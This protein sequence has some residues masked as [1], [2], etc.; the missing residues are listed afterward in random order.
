MKTTMCIACGQDFASRNKLFKHLNDSGHGVASRNDKGGDINK[1]GDDDADDGSDTNRPQL[2]KGNDAYYEYY[3]RQKICENEQAWKEA[4]HELR[5]P[6]PVAYRIHESSSISEFSAQLLALIEKREL[7]GV[8]DE[9]KLISPETMPVAENQKIFQQW[10]FNMENKDSVPKLRMTITPHFHHRSKSSRNNK[11]GQD[12]QSD[13]YS[14]ILHALQELGAIHRQELVSAIPPLVLWAACS[15]EETGI[16]DGLIVADLCAAPG[17][18]SLQML[19]MLYTSTENNVPS[20]LLVVN[21][22]D[23]NRIVTLCQRSRHVPRAPMLAINMDA[24]YF[25]G[26]RRRVN[27]SGSKTGEGDGV[28]NVREKSGYKQKYDKVLCDV[29]CTG[30]G[31]TRKNK[32]IWNAWS[33]AHSMSLHRLQRKILRRAMELLRPGGM[34]VYSTCSLNPLEDEAVVASV[35]G[36]VG[37]VNAMEIVPLPDWLVRKCR[38]LNGLNGSWHVPNP[39]FGKKGMNDMYQRFQDVPIEHQGGVKDK[40]KKGGQINPSMFPPEK[41]SELLKQLTNCGRFVPQPSIG[42]DSGGFFVACIRRLHVGELGPKGK[43]SQSTS[44]ESDMALAEEPMQEITTKNNEDSPNEAGDHGPSADGRCLREGDWICVSCNEINF[45]KRGGSKCFGCKARKPHSLQKDK[46][47]KIQEPLLVKP[48]KSELEPFFE[49]FGIHTGLRSSF[50]LNNVRLIRRAK[51]HA[52]VV[53]SEALSK[54]SI[55]K[56]WS[57]VRELGITLAAFPN[58]EAHEHIAQGREFRLFDESLSILARYATRRHLKLHPVPFQNALAQSVRLL[59]ESSSPAEVERVK[60]TLDRSVPAVSSLCQRD[61]WYDS[62]PDSMASPGYFIVS[63]ECEIPNTRGGMG[64]FSLCG[65]IDAQGTVDL[66]TSL[67]VAAAMLVLLHKYSEVCSSDP[68]MNKRR[69][70]AV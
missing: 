3:L 35:I 69:R 8:K 36:D 31:T 62:L 18:K 10:S 57:P 14:P 22:S 7:G 32:Q 2:S 42:F 23:R 12:D 15:K 11:S 13:M 51:E 37:G 50:P 44:G 26:M 16:N 28:A 24:R 55:S 60:A 63:C 65:Y 20:G 5:R 64:R 46:G 61:M 4:Y 59:L 1:E 25:P 29:P 49:F 70:R 68:P 52:I 38:A 54:L 17:S 34:V 27:R 48:G 9:D 41:D 19:D 40:G 30:D 21:D 45:A 43:T 33:I 58:N 39:N 56:S 53:V 6:L 47:Y 66:K 67:R